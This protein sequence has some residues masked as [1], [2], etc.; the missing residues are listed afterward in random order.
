MKPCTLRRVGMAAA[1]FATLAGGCEEA[2]GPATPAERART[3]RALVVIGQGNA[4]RILRAGYP[5]PVVARVT[6]MVSRPVAGAVIVWRGPAASGRVSPDSVRTDGDGLVEAVWTTGTRAGVQELVAVV[7]GNQ[8]V[9]DRTAL[10]VFADTVMGTLVLGAL[11]DT[12][13]RGDTTQV[14]I[15]D[16]RDRHGN[17]YALFGIQPDNPPPVEFMSLDPAVASLVST[18]GHAVRVAGVATGTARIVA[19]SGATADTLAL[20][21]RNPSPPPS[22]APR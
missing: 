13:A 10:I 17:P 4:H 8:N 9:T 19:R 12:V 2:T 14:R 1:L 7:D 18:N 15:T 6:D 5:I 20:V 16:A 11:R 21:V 22:R 3:M